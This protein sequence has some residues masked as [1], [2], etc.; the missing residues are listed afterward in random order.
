MIEKTEA[1]IEGALTL[2]R[3]VITLDHAVRVVRER[4]FQIRVG[5]KVFIGD[6]EAPDIVEALMPVDS[7][8]VFFKT[9][10][11]EGK[12]PL[13]IWLR[14]TDRIRFTGFTFDPAKPYGDAGSQF[15]LFQGPAIKPV[16][17]DCKLII[18]HIDEVWCS[19][20]SK[21]STHVL[22][23]LAHS[24][25]KPWE[26]TVTSIVLQSG[27]GTGKSIIMRMLQEMWAP[28]SLQIE[29][30]N[31][32]AGNH[33]DHLAQNM[34]VCAEE[35]SMRGKIAATDV[36]K[37]F[38]SSKTLLINPKGKSA[39]TVNNYARLIYATNH[40]WALQASKEA[41][42][43][44]VA[45][46]SSHRVGD[47]DYFA[48]LARVADS[49]AGQSAFLYFLLNRDI[50]AFDPQQRPDTKALDRQKR[51]TMDKL[52]H[53]L[54]WLAVVL[55]SGEF[56]LE[57]RPGGLYRSQSWRDDKAVLAD[58][59]RESYEYFVVKKKNP[60]RWP[61][62]AKRLKEIWPELDHIRI[63]VDGGERKY[64]YNLPPIEDARG[65]FESYAG[66]VLEP[67]PDD[68]S[69]DDCS[70]FDPNNK[71]ITNIHNHD[72]KRLA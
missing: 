10:D 14:S 13:H 65:A 50:S 39:F 69:V 72:Q 45:V 71:K 62:V 48:K 67:L 59:L 17:G 64:H 37:N 1:S 55:E 42:R 32:I 43:W 33:N 34:L 66:L 41:R 70:I 60:P 54:A 9:E 23:W 20:D 11:I 49:Q 58:V 56:E 26:R 27:E 4:F 19:S 47:F 36:I 61:N 18:D 38:V 21:Q 35:F 52:D 3:T 40:P 8:K 30:E 16:E 12:D 46:I 28:H 5:G 29:S 15:N 2:G 57:K 63:R 25:Q 53:P 44:Y 22:D 51:Q 31:Q 24:F 7:F 68:Y 6:R